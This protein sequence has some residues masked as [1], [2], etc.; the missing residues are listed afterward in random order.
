MQIY[1]LIYFRI[2]S[3]WLYFEYFTFTTVF[4]CYISELCVLFT[5]LI[6]NNLQT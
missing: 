5:A 4:Q 2:K 6:I 1:T 3:R